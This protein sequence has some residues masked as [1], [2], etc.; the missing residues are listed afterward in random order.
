MPNAKK[1]AEK[2]DAANS[3]KEAETSAK[4]AAADD[5]YWSQGAKGDSKANKEAD[6]KAELQRKK[7]EKARLEAEEDASNSRTASKGKKAPAKKGAPGI[8]DFLATAGLAPKGGP[9]KKQ[10]GLAASNIDDAID[11]LSLTNKKGGPVSAMDIEKHPERRFKAAYT[12][13]EEKRISEMKEE[14]LGLRLQQMKD[15]CYKEFQKHPD[16]PFNQVTARHDASKD[17]LKAIAEH[18]RRKTEQRLAT[19]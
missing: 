2:V 18:E 4:K 8:D 1:R 7:D 11:A 15:L 3:R 14:G 13:F 6:K 5:A 12:A 16:N 9:S 19:R 17:E 10:A